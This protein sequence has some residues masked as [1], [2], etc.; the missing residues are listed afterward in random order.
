M[1]DLLG[2]LAGFV[3]M[4]AQKVAR[5]TRR[6]AILF[7]LA[8]L[9]GLTAYVAAIVAA[10]IYASAIYGPVATAIVVC[11]AAILLMLVVL[12]VQRAAHIRDQ[13]QAARTN[14]QLKSMATL[15]AALVPALVKSGALGWTAAAGGAIYLARELL[16]PSSNGRTTSDPEERRMPPARPP[17]TNGAINPHAARSRQENWR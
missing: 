3:G 15:G 16:R 17:Q 13:R 11:L 5:H 6:N 10:S 14:A 8:G 1:S 7:A 12:A 9:L 2:D 4:E